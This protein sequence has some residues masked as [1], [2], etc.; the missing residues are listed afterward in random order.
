M[1]RRMKIAGR[2]VSGVLVGNKRNNIK[3]A[4]R[5]RIQQ[6][7]DEQTNRDRLSMKQGQVND[8]IVRKVP[9]KILTS[10]FMYLRQKMLFVSHWR[11]KI[12]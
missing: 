9:G 4:S 2:R 10:L 11:T 3:N 6:L 1:V 7:I 8:D 12:P 5:K